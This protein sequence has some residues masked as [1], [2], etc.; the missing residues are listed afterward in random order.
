MLK[1][2]LLAS[3]LTLAATSASDTPRSAFPFS[4][5]G[6]SENSLYVPLSATEGW[7]G[8]GVAP[9]P[10]HGA[11]R[12]VQTPQQRVRGAVVDLEAKVGDDWFTFCTGVAV[13]KNTVLTQKHCVV[14]AK[15]R[16]I[17]I[18]YNKK[19]CPK[20]QVIAFDG[21][22]NVLVHTCQSF[23]A[24]VKIRGYVPTIGEKVFEYGHPYGMPVLYR[25]GYMTAQWYDKGQLSY[26][27]TGIY[28]VVWVWDM[29]STHGDSGGPIFSMK[30]ELI[31]TTSFGIHAEGD[32]FQVMGCYPP[33][34]SKQALAQIE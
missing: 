20:D 14:A 4:Q 22:D 1:A 16:G 7:E 6:A 25:E 5:S 33:W 15:E 24:H 30:G 13:G 34:F 17:S 23:P 12:A 32:G 2:L 29:N 31:C 11:Q 21:T 8:R 28:G 3:L 10:L 18:Y 9:S 27:D 26:G 19:A